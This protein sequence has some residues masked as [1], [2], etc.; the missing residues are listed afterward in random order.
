MMKRMRKTR[1]AL[2]V[3]TVLATAGLSQ[4]AQITSWDMSKV[5]FG[6]PTSITNPALIF[7]PFNYIAPGSLVD[8]NTGAVATGGFSQVA[9]Q[10]MQVA[11]TLFPMVL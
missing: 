7:D 1:V 2:A 11:T 4:A 10:S 6:V 9:G 3:A 5:T 8:P